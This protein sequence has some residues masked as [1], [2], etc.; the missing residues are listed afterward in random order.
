[1]SVEFTKDALDESQARRGA[2]LELKA[3]DLVAL[4]QRILDAGLPKV[5][6]LGNDFFYFTTP[7]GQVMRIVSAR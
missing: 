5:K 1:L 6:Y 2:W 4:K 7:D 3:D